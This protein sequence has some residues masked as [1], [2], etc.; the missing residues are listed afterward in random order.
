MEDALSDSE[1]VELN[2]SVAASTAIDPDKIDELVAQPP[3]MTSR[4]FHNVINVVTDFSQW[5]DCLT[6]DH[7]DVLRKLQAQVLDATRLCAVRRTGHFQRTGGSGAYAPD[8]HGGA[9]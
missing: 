6:A 4:E 2:V 3:S 9:R 7:L 5:Q 1:W 8:R